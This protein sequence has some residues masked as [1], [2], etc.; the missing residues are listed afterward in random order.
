MSKYSGKL[1]N[2]SFDI[3]ITDTSI[4]AIH[5]YAKAT[6]IAPT[7]GNCFFISYRVVQNT[8]SLQ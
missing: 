5:S 1:V 4:Q 2:M 3:V 8:I 7:I 6:E